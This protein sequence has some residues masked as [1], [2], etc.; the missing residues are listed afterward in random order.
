MESIAEA[1]KSLPNLKGHLGR[2]FDTN[3]K[4]MAEKMCQGLNEDEGDQHIGDGYDCRECRNKGFVFVVVED[5]YKGNVF[6]KEKSIPC[7][8]MKIRASIRRMKKS[9]LESIIAKCTF[10]KYNA[11]DDW[12]KLIKERA[13]TFAKE[14]DNLEDKWFYLGGAV[15][16]GKTH[17]CTAIVRDQLY[18][19]KEAR[20]ML[21]DEDSKPLKASANDEK[22]YAELIEPLKTVEVL[23]IDDFLKTAKKDKYRD[24]YYDPTPADLKLAYEIINHRYF[25]PDL[26]TIFSSERYITEII[27]MDP[28][29][30][31]RI[32]E[33][34]K[35]N[36]NA[37]NVT[38]LKE[39]NYRTRDM[40]TI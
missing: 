28:A 35:E 9:G 13:Q 37:C 38:R 3:P 34:T 16:G 6:Y 10:D 1:V 7:K 8:C 17:L 39:R 18:K 21:W 40:Q 4:K 29:V 15:G 11:T 5:S 31:S 22:R 33:K 14:V 36:A 27:D 23:Y 30:G 25:V 19:G 32:Y 12:Q 24:E 20:Y 26:I 2:S